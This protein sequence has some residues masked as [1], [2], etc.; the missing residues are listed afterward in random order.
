[1]IHY[2]VAPQILSNS[3]NLGAAWEQLSRDKL[4]INLNC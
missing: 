3:Y 4:L 2:Q 1:V